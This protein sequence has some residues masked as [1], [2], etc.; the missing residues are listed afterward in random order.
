MCVCFTWPQSVCLSLGTNMADMGFHICYSDRKV[1]YPQNQRLLY[2]ANLF[3]VADHI[4]NV[5]IVY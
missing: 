4:L 3:H 5:D 2:S 1:L